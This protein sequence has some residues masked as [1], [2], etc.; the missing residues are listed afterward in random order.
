MHA[1]TTSSILPSTMME[2]VISVAINIKP[3][4][5]FCTIV[6]LYV[7]LCKTTKKFGHDAQ[8]SIIIGGRRNQRHEVLGE[9]V[10]DGRVAG[11]DGDVSREDLG[12]IVCVDIKKYGG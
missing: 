8:S 9:P 10:I 7:H 2:G 1:Q 12:H 4:S 6:E 5:I 11:L 3:I